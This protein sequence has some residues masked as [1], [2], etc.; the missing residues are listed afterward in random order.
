[1]A[2]CAA[3]DPAG[4]YVGQVL[5]L[6]D[7]HARAL[8]QEG[9]AA[10]GP[11][12]PFGGALVGMLVIAVALLGWRML[13]GEGAPLREGVALA[14]RLGI[15]LAL[16]SQWAAFQPLIYD[17]ALRGP[18][19][20]AGQILSP[21]GLGGQD[22]AGLAARVQAVSAALGEL[23]AAVQP[24]GDAQA[25]GQAPGWQAAAPIS[26]LTDEARAGLVAANQALVVTALGGMVAVRVVTG[27]LL[28]LAPIF[29]AAA[30]FDAGRRLLAGWLRV[31][32]GTAL[33]AVAVP[34]VLALELAVM[35]PQVRALQA[36]LGRGAMPMAMPGDLR[37]TTLVFA[38]AMA[39]ALFGA[40]WAA[41]GLGLPDKGRW[42]AE[43]APSPE[44]MG[45]ATAALPVVPATQGARARDQGRS[46]A[47]MVG[48]AAQAMARR[49]AAGHGLAARPIRTSAVAGLATRRD[50]EVA[51]A[52][53]SAPVAVR[54]RHHRPS[55]GAMRRDSLL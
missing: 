43:A 18:Q 29:L 34:M 36:A 48:D 53:A 16:A 40:V 44:R 14:L 52:S 46:R 35:E 15:V 28:A 30:V 39:A 4:G 50:A 33:G 9:Y 12:S 47:Q 19:D 42:R 45:G 24:G 21:G 41:A 3:F 54:S 23:G 6:V 37:V 38:L 13:L 31:L 11:G 2:G 55:L 22:E 26:V 10:L 8:G 20:L 5:G 32:A 49:D 25:A 1:M 17:V 27:L 51:S 7:C